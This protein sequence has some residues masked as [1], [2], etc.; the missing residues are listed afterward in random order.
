MLTLGGTANG[1]EG[2]GVV[3][4]VGECAGDVDDAPSDKKARVDTQ[5]GLNDCGMVT[6][7]GLQSKTKG[8]I[9]EVD[10]V[11][12]ETTDEICIVEGDCLQK[13][14]NSPSIEAGKVE[15]GAIQVCRNY[16]RAYGDSWSS[17]G[18]NGF[19]KHLYKSGV[20]FYVFEGCKTIDMVFPLRRTKS[21]SVTFL[22]MFVSVK[23]LSQR[24]ENRV[25]SHDRKSKIVRNKMCFL[26]LGCVRL[27]K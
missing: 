8:H 16:L 3:A 22:P 2:D 9:M 24:C 11:E 4:V 18:S 6:G 13:E 23:P 15:F 10:H 17:L 14:N 5:A 21:D 19:L 27:T 20:G 26:S 25:P 1:V 12:L 7:D